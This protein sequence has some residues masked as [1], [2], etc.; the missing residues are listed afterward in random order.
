MPGA[1]TPAGGYRR[2]VRP[3]RWGGHPLSQFTKAEQTWID[4]RK[5]FDI[6]EDA[7]MRQQVERERAQL[8]QLVL[9]RASENRG[10]RVAGASR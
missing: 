5:Y 7:A 8:I 6:A 4:G 10:Q 1:I 3:A 9:E 2:A